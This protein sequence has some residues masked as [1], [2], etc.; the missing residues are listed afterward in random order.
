MRPSLILLLMLTAVPTSRPDVPQV[1][2]RLKYMPHGVPRDTVPTYKVGSPGFAV[3]QAYTA[4]CRVWLID[5]DYYLLT[6]PGEVEATKKPPGEP[7]GEMPG[8]LH[9]GDLLPEPFQ[10]WRVLGPANGPSDPRDHSE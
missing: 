6:R 1:Q 7:P 3:I 8:E 2:T 4:K 5:R 10:D 9:G